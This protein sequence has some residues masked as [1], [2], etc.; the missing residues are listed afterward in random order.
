MR[1]GLPVAYTLYRAL[2]S[3]VHLGLVGFAVVAAVLWFV[4]DN[5]G[6]HLFAAIWEGL[7][8]AQRNVANAIPFPWGPWN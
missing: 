8:D 7:T 4:H 5:Q 3:V 2:W 6:A 1:N